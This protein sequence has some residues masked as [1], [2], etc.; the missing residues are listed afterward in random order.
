M[1]DIKPHLIEGEDGAGR[2][3]D[4]LPH[5]NEVFNED[6]LQKL[7]FKHPE[8]L[9][10]DHI[11]RE[12]APLISIGREIKGIDNLF[13]SRFGLLTIVETKLWRN[14]E[15]HKAVVA[16]IVHYAITLSGWS[17]D[18]LD[19]CV[20]NSM[21]RY[22]K[23]SMSIYEIVKRKTH[24][25]ETTESEFREL[26]QDC[27]RQGRFALLIVGDN[28]QPAATRLA[29]GMGSHPNLLY[30][31]GLVELRCH[32]LEHGSDWPWVVIPRLAETRIAEVR[33]VVKV[34]QQIQLVDKVER[35]EP[36]IVVTAGEETADKK[37][38]SPG[39]TSLPVFIAS[40]VAYGDIFD[41]YLRQWKTAGYTIFWGMVGFSLRIR[42]RGKLVTVFE[43]H[44]WDV[45]VCRDKIQEKY[46]LPKKNHEDYKSDLKASSVITAEFLVKDRKFIRIE[47]MAEEDV[48]ILLEATDRLARSWSE[49]AKKENGAS[50]DPA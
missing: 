36:E 25:F 20:S 22:D 38:T 21:A 17:Y 40:V 14:P 33:A 11:H 1:Y 12:Y 3:L 48:R 49:A 34:V 31:I 10:I 8:I 44:P 42:W 4:P 16:Q 23:Q 30:S 27:L 6:W 35:A 47:E 2:A 26:V 45:G 19:E 50:P 39:S 15:A 46:D 9:P 24:D 28:I 13:I 37:D 18:N 5:K 29:E 41:S 32:K 43:A 7:L